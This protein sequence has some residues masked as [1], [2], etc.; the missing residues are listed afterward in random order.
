M[1]LNCCNMLPWTQILIFFDKYHKYHKIKGF[2]R[3]PIFRTTIEIHFSESIKE[4]FEYSESLILF[5]W[6]YQIYRSIESEKYA[7][8]GPRKS[9]VR[10]V[11]FFV[12]GSGF[13][14]PSSLWSVCWFS[15]Q[16]QINLPFFIHLWQYLPTLTLFSPAVIC[17][18]SV[19]T[20]IWLES[21]LMKESLEK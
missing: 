20:L 16:F 3:P 15:D 11:N 6:R 7:K 12:R 19:V 2:S 21:L 4:L 5:L 10:S 9:N 8:M 13:S 17:L 1:P 18:K 14:G